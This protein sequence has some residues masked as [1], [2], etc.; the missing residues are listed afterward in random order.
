MFLA[1]FLPPCPQ[2]PPSL[3]Q[4]AELPLLLLR[5]DGGSLRG[6]RG[7]GEGGAG[8]GG[9]GEGGEA[10]VDRGP[11]AGRGLGLSGGPRALLQ[12]IQRQTDKV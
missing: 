9:G 8:E 12:T 5:P 11:G 1:P 4:P 3:R 2:L 10:A 6:G 7:R